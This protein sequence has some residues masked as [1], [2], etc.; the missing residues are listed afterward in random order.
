MQK[1]DELLEW[2]EV[3][4]SQGFQVMDACLLAE[5]YYPPINVGWPL[6]ILRVCDREVAGA[7]RSTLLAAY[8]EDH[9]VVVMPMHDGDAKETQ[10]KVILT[11]LGEVQG[12]GESSCVYVPPLPAG[13]DFTDLQETVAHLRSPVGC[14]WDREQTLA[15]LRK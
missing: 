10:I 2:L 7:V 13:Q 12:F 3:D 11:V 6:L 1:L 4:P 9:E 14:P 15:S 8:P 5:K